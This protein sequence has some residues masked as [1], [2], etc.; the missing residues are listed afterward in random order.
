MQQQVGAMM[1]A[2]LGEPGQRRGGDFG[3]RFH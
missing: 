2:E 3:G 1:D